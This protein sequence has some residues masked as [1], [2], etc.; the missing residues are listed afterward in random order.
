MYWFATVYASDT[1]ALVRDTTK[2]DREKAIKKSW[3]DKEPGRAL[4]AKKSRTKYMLTLKEEL[5][6]EE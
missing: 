6:P 3:E 5:T 2:E 1:V 4:N